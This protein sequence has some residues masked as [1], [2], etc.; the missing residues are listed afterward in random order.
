MENTNKRLTALN[1]DSVRSLIN[2]INEE[3]IMKEDVL[4]L[5]HTN[6]EYYL[7]YYKDCE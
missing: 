5:L 3:H 7:L 6:G 1:T 2:I 4:D